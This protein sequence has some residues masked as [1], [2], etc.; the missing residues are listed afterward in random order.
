MRFGVYIG[1]WSNKDAF[2]AALPG[3][4]DPNQH[5]S[6]NRKVQNRSRKGRP[7]ESLSTLR[8]KLSYF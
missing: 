8:L 2:F 5:L 4:A 7:F 6:R 1:L 3:R